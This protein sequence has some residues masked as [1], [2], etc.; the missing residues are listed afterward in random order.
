MSFDQLKKNRSKSLEKLSSQLDK[1]SSNGY[2]DPLKEKYW[3]LSKD[4]AGNGF[5]IIRFLPEPDGEDMPF[6][7]V[8]SH[9]FQGPGGWFIEN[10]LTTLG[11]DDP[12]SA[13][14]SKLWNS[15]TDDKG[16]ERSQVRAQK[17]KLKYHSNILVIKDSANPDN[18]GKVFLFAYGKKIF[19]KLNDLMNPEFEDETPVNPFD[20]WE[21]ANF[22]LK[23]RKVEGYPNYDKS[24]F[25]DPEP[26]FGGDEDKLKE[27]YEQLHS[28]KDL[29]DEKYFKTYDELEAKLYKV[30]GLSGGSSAKSNSKAEDLIEE[31]LDMSKLGDSAEEPKKK[32]SK[33]K[34]EPVASSDDDDDDLEFFR[35]LASE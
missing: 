24:E 16:P 27:V 33:K 10:S 6:I 4:S 32:A 25:D 18:E 35:N 22:K 28:L 3:T 1:M 14:N 5:A 11:K 15:S 13:F 30:L 2:S 31:D 9:G 8:F 12:V 20:F 19:D 7:R 29:H 17:R 26:L 21:G 23:V 34:E